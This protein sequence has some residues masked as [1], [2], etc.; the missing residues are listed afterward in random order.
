MQGTNH[1]KEGL[2]QEKKCGNFVPRAAR[3]LKP[4]PAKRGVPK[5]GC[6]NNVRLNS[7]QLVDAYHH[8]MTPSVFCPI[9]HF[10]S[11]FSRTPWYPPILSTTTL[12]NLV[13]FLTM[14]W[15]AVAPTYSWSVCHVLAFTLVVMFTQHDDAQDSD[16][17]HWSVCFIFNKKIV[18]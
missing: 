17:I 7:H 2:W 14:R 11:L 9:S 12:S 16:W 4:L 6:H 13:S 3:D 15:A 8:D 10:L 5:C 18:L 1:N